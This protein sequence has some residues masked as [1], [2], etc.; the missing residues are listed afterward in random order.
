[1]TAKE[2]LLQVQILDTK[3]RHKEE[4]REQLRRAVEGRGIAYD[5][6]RVQTSPSNVQESA[7]IKYLDLEVEIERLVDDY[8]S[9]KD[10]II[11]QIHSIS[12]KDAD[13]YI[14]ILYDHYVPDEKHKV[15]SLEQIAVDMNYNYTY[16][17]E[18]HGRALQA[19]AQNTRINPK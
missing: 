6:E 3:I 13:K 18:L 2:Y 7:I 17:C 15:K 9:R 5:K 1:M 14:R 10:A 16:T 8:I 19:F 12:G 4:E 11:N